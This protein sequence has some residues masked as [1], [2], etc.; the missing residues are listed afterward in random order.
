MAFNWFKTRNPVQDYHRAMIAHHGPDSSLA[1]GWRGRS[2]QLLRFEVLAGIGDMNGCT[3]LDAGCGYADLYPFLENRYPELGAY[4]GIEQLPEMIARAGER[5]PGIRLQQGDFMRNKLPTCDYVLASGS[6]NYGQAIFP[7][8][9]KLYSACTLG[10]GFNLLRE[11]SEGVLQAYDPDEIVAFA[12]T[13]AP[14]VSLRDD[15]S[16]ED[17]SVFLYR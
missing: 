6:L 2:D 16:P 5:Y 3:V 17:F 14:K 7:A 9:R 10:L 13:L 4:H 11:I 15:Y 8:I 1:L 12:K